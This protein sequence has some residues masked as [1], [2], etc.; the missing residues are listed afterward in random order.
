MVLRPHTLHQEKTPEGGRARLGWIGFGFPNSVEWKIP[1]GVSLKPGIYWEEISRLFHE[2]Y[3]ELSGAQL[4]GEYRAN[5]CLR[6]LMVLLARTQEKKPASRPQVGGLST[7]QIQM[8]QAAAEYLRRNVESPLQ[9]EALARYHSIQ[10]PHLSSLFRRHFGFSPQTFLQQERI[11]KA[12]ALL[13]DPHLTTR[14]V[15]LQCGYYDESDFVRR[16]RR[17]A[18][19]TPGRWRE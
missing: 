12:K 13:E 11:K 17:A 3:E 5:L 18:G 16:F 4:G 14:Q 19:L 15:A 7:R 10:G 2:I 6:E 9:L 8:V 1:C